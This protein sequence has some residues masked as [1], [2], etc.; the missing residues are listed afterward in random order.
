[1]LEGLP[2]GLKK[3]AK[4]LA[5]AALLLSA[6]CG[7]PLPPQDPFH[8]GQAKDSLGRGNH[9]YQRGCAKEAIGWFQAGLEEARLADD[10]SLI[11]KALNALG[12]AYLRV[13]DLAAAAL[14]LERA[15][16][17]SSS[18]ADSPELQ[19]V[20]GNL[21]ALAFQ[22][23]RLDDAN[24]Y[25]LSAI[26]EA[27]KKGASPALFHCDLA[28]LAMARN[29]LSEFGRRAA[30]AL[31]ASEGASD[32]VRADALNLSAQASLSGGDP[33]QAESYLLKAL[34]LDRHSENQVGLAQDLETL[35]GIQSSSNRPM[36]AAASLDRAFFLR[37]ALGDRA[38]QRR[39]MDLLEKLSASS[40]HPKSLAPYRDVIRDPAL[41]DPLQRLCP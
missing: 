41:F 28:R 25:W 12:A 27:Q 37:A 40:G 31:A 35:A 10:L 24:D 36:E 17:L 33:V 21:G 34:E 15:Y 5:L 32:S 11:V 2:C 6:A 38:S 7:G 4:L 1:M 14:A 8:L 23:G 19:T 16:D 20:L 13:G 30:L 29:D 18:R 9:W 39:I 26:A 3:G 22:A